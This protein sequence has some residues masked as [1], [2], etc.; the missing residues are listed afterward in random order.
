VRLSSVQKRSLIGLIAAAAMVTLAACSSGST[1]A[2]GNQPGRVATSSTPTATPS[3][4]QAAKWYVSVGDSYAAGWQATG[5]GSGHTT[6]NGFAYQL[7]SEAPSKGYRLTLQNFGCGGATTTSV[8]SSQGCP[9]VALGPGATPYPTTTQEAAAIAFIKAH[10]G[11]IGLITVSIGG[12]DITKCAAEANPVPCVAGAINSVK[13]NVTKLVKDLRA[14][15]G[16]GVPIRGITY[17]DVILGEYLSGQSGQQL[18]SLSVTAF[19]SLINPALS[20]AYKS[21]GGQLV[22]VTTATGAY[23]PLSQTTTLAPYGTIPVAVAKV[24]SLTYYCQYKDIHPHTDGYKIIADLLLN[25]LPANSA[26]STNSA[27]SSG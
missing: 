7:T 25:S 5:Q 16:P 20:A 27:S 23:T 14:A 9:A 11:Q 22:D 8:L 12:N 24:C 18:A 15:A 1:G 2:K 4:V 13:T 19:K 17:P 6:R 26:S 10:P 21:V 3:P